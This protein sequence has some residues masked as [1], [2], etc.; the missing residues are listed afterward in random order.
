MRFTKRV[1]PDTKQEEGQSLALLVLSMAMLLGMVALSVDVGSIVVTRQQEQSAADAAV[2]AAVAVIFEGGDAAAAIAEAEAY[3][4]ANGF[5]SGVQVNIPPTTGPNAGDINSV[6][7]IVSRAVSPIFGSAVGIGPWNL[8]SRAVGSLIPQ[9]TGFGVIT[10]HPTAC[11]SLE[12]GSSSRIEVANGGIYVNSNCTSGHQALETGSSSLLSADEVSVVGGYENSG[13]INPT[14]KT[15]QAPIPDPWASLTPPST[16]SVGMI[17]RT[18]GDCRIRSNRTFQPGLYTCSP[19]VIDTNSVTFTAGD[20]IFRGGL[21][22]KDGTA[23]FGRG[24]YVIDGGGFNMASNT[25]AVNVD[26]MLIYN[27]CGASCGGVDWLHFQSSSRLTAEPYGAPYDNLLIWQ[28]AGN[29]TQVDFNSH[30]EVITGTGTGVYAPSATI[31][32]D[33]GST[34]PMQFVALNVHIGSNARIV[35]DAQNLPSAA[36]WT[37]A[38]TE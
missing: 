27:A 12:V 3:A 37:Y 11:E 36:V 5:A 16:S 23:N 30:S 6:E 24:V 29:G 28:Q 13:T 17:N 35:V 33:C 19:L 14:P 15:G 18:P 1:Q 25:R 2:L 38:L 26:G 8:S 31:E 20:Y 9:N 21:E 22:I 10:L 7:V 4:S 34:V 32:Y